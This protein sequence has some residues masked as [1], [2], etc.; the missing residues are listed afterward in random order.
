VV[1][2]DRGGQLFELDLADFPALRP[3]ACVTNDYLCALAVNRRFAAV[4]AGTRDGR[5]CICSLADGAFRFSCDV[6]EAPARIAITD[7]WGFIVVHSGRRIF[8]FNVNGRL[9][10]S[11]ECPFAVRCFAT[12]RLVDSSDFCAIADGSQVR[13]FETFYLRLDECVCPVK[14]AVVAMSY[15]QQQR[16]LAVITADGDLLLFPC[17]Q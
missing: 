12:W 6:E 1:L 10:R 5:V 3:I 9:I 13:I 2:S 7:G 4:A 17:P 14:A 16:S 8:L 15:L 11:V